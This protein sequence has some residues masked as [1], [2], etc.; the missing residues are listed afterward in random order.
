MHVL[1]TFVVAGSLQAQL[2]VRLAPETSQ[3]FEQYV[4]KAESTLVSKAKA[5]RPLPW[6]GDEA[7][8]RVRG[9][10]LIVQS[11]N[12][13][14]APVRGGLIHDWMGGAF[15]P[16]TTIS[17]AA[18]LIQDFARHKDWYPEIVDSKLI[19][20]EGR[21][22]QGLWILR[23][24][25]MLTVVVRADL[26][27]TLTE[28][29]PTHSYVVSRSKPIVEIEDYGGPNQSDYAAG[30]GHGFLWRFN[31]YWTLHEADGGVY[32]E[33]RIIS[34][35]REVPSGLGWI[36]SP[37]IRSMPRES[38]ESTLRNTREALKKL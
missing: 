33:C 21:D 3:D 17:K 35:S 32:A 37:F 19:A 27:S 4:A 16:K 38:L 7:K 24:K 18:S 36:V 2:T 6:F 12:A 13:Q 28:V 1:T 9:G 15:F 10:E 34:L 22:V 8:P 5:N 29:S 31:G 25:A 26:D 20:R 23:R 30:E 14:P 11:I